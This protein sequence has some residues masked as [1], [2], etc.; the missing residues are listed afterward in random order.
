MSE[1]AKLLNQLLEGRLSAVHTAVIG[2]ITRI[3]ANRADVQPLQGGYP[4]LVNLPLAYQRY[5]VTVTAGSSAGTYDCTG[6]VYEA[7]DRVLVL[8]LERAGDNVGGRKHDL[9]DG[10]IAGVI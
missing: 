5:K 10:I 8:F 6:P 3:N 9:S 7:G 1:F 2:R 4:L